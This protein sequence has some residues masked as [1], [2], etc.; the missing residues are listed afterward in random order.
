[1][2][3]IEHNANTNFVVF[4]GFKHFALDSRKFA[5]NWRVEWDYGNYIFSVWDDN[6]KKFSELK[7]FG[8]NQTL[9]LQQLVTVMWENGEIEQDVQDWIHEAIAAIQILL[10]W[11]RNGRK[12]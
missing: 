3:I 8:G 12:F 5:E 10:F 6:C 4:D 11:L 7:V 9:K 2:R 1:M